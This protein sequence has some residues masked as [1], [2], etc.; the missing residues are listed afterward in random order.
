MIQQ[1]PFFFLFLNVYVFQFAKR[2]SRISM[3]TII[4]GHKELTI[5]K[6]FPYILIERGLFF[7]ILSIEGK[8][9][10]KRVISFLKQAFKQR[11]VHFKDKHLLNE[12]IHRHKLEHMELLN[13]TT[14]YYSFIAQFKDSNSELLFNFIIRSFYSQNLCEASLLLKV[15][16]T[17][18][19]S[20]VPL[21][22]IQCFHSKD[23]CIRCSYSCLTIFFQHVLTHVNSFTIT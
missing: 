22:W 12:L 2:K 6:L 20:P 14:E 9:F 3:P 4:F 11:A 21:H 16:S 15:N 18:V 17:I 5:E 23:S 10:S 7:Q 19:A 1:S 13:L 8:G